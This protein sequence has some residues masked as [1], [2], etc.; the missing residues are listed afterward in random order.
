[1]AFAFREACLASAAAAPS[2]GIWDGC[3]DNDGTFKLILGIILGCLDSDGAELD[4]GT[5]GMVGVSVGS[6]GAT[7]V[8]GFST[9]GALLIDGAMAGPMVGVITTLEEGVPSAGI[10]KTP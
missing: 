3:N 4:V 2:L 10:A 1:L 5:M 8:A 7:D 6:L 9:E